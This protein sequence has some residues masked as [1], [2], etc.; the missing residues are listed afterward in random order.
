MK[1][2]FFKRE[3]PEQIIDCK[4]K[5]VNF[6]ENKKSERNNKKRVP[7][8]V[9]YHPMLEGLRKII[10]DNLYLLYMNDEVKQNSK[11][12]ISLQIF[13]GCLPQNLLSSL[14]NI[15]FQMSCVLS[16]L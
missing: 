1:L 8:V 4:L 2:W 15:L 10:K 9:T 12:I 7:F 16:H 13:K 3:Y 5:K 6:R 11:Q 14:L